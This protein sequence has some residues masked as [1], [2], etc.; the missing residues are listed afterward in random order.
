MILLY[1]ESFGN[2]RKFGRLARRVARRKPILAMKGGRTRSGAKAAGSH[3]AALAGS[4]QAVD[5]LFLQ[6]GVIR[7]ETLEELVDTAG[8]LASQPLPLG[9]RV[10]VLTNAGGLG[11]LCAD[12]CEAAG[13]E[14]P[15]LT[16]ATREA[17]A[18]KLPREASLANPIDMLGSATA[19][20]YESVLPHVLADPD[21]DAV[22]VLFVPPVVASAEDVAEAVVV[23]VESANVTDK[24]VLAAFVSAGGTPS[25]LLH[26]PR[27]VAAFAYPESAAR[28]LGRAAERAAWLRRPAGRRPGAGRDRRGGRRRDRPRG[29]R[30]LERRLARPGAACARCSA[31]TASPF[32]GE[33]VADDRRR[34]RRGRSGARL[35]GRGQDGRGG[36]AQVRPQAARA[37]PRRR[38]VGPGRGG[39]DRDCRSSSS[40]W[41]RA[42][43]SC[44]PASSRI[45]SSGRSSPAGPAASS[46]S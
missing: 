11:I 26:E 30:R 36:R 9:N 22:I 29:A 35:P 10:A 46:P 45:R 2:P 14:L 7:A 4:E 18:L 15:T 1:L 27:R 16:A 17:L 12:A 34:G 44:S 25:A 5:A 21:V 13:L 24:P 38:G 8:L 28:A 39:A 40:R 31:P 42:A 20:T 3:T 37:R 23:A 6:A 41:S 19:A 33:R 43:S 32:V